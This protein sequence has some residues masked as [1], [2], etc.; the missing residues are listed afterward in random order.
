MKG[1]NEG[2]GPHKLTKKNGA[3]SSNPVETYVLSDPD[4]ILLELRRFMKGL[5]VTQQ[6]QRLFLFGIVCSTA[7]GKCKMISHKCSVSQDVLIQSTESRHAV[8]HRV[9]GTERSE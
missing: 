5:M 4:V 1:V 6:S 2:A 8:Q 9:R 3:S 7:S